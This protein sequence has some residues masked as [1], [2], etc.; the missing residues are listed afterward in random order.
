[1]CLTIWFKRII[2]AQIYKPSSW[3]DIQRH[4]QL[5]QLEKL[6]AAKSA[7]FRL[8]LPLVTFGYLVVTCGS[9][10]LPLV[11]LPFLSLP[12][13]TL[14]YLVL[15]WLT[16]SYIALPFLTFLY[17][18][19]PIITYTYLSLPYLSVHNSATF[20]MLLLKSSKKVVILNE[21]SRK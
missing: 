13:L 8:F 16:S 11:I 7:Y 20:P 15:P 17:L 1:M 2:H 14:P 10:W 12:W 5:N 4:F 18:S 6:E 21:I 19:V 9:L 3:V